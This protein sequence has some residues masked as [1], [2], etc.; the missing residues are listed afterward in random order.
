MPDF[1]EKLATHRHRGFHFILVCQQASKQ[2]H[3]FIQGL[4]D[5]HEHIRRKFG[6]KKAIIL[7]WDRYQSNTSNSDQKKFWAYPPSLMKRSL[8]ESTVQDTT[9][10]RWPWWMFVGPALIALVIY[11][12]YNAQAFWTGKKPHDQQAST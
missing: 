10:K 8:Y 4:V 5:H 6:F 2:L 9:E 12:V 11:L 7:S 1:I 3:P